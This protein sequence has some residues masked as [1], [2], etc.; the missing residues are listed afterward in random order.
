MFKSLGWFAL[1]IPAFLLFMACSPI[2]SQ[3]IEVGNIDELTPTNVL[4]KLQ[5]K[6]IKSTQGKGQV[7]KFSF[8]NP[9]DVLVLVVKRFVGFDNEYFTIV[10][11]KNTKGQF[12]KIATAHTYLDLTSG[13][14]DIELNQLDLLDK[15]ENTNLYVTN[16]KIKPK[17]L[18]KVLINGNNLKFSGISDTK[19]IGQVGYNYPDAKSVGLEK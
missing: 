7:G 5:G 12:T 14:F 10:Y 19:K 4:S 6:E 3:P 16:G 1:I 9:G 2:I 11:G 13:K 17:V 8:D 18:A 15:G